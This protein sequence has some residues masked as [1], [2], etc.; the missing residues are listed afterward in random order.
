MLRRTPLK[1]KRETPRRNEGR[2]AH[3]RL[4]PRAAGKTA[5]EARH[6][7]KVASL[8]CLI[9]AGPANIHHVMH[10]PG[11]EKRRDHRFVAPLCR[12]HHQGDHGVHGKYCGSEKAFEALWGVDLVRWCIHAWLLRD[13]PDA[14]FWTDGVTRC[15]EIA[16]ALGP[17]H[18][19]G[20]GAPR[21]NKALDPPCPTARVGGE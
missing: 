16:K 18:K 10:A 1:A 14:L 19:G 17:G 3:Q 2:V 12:E 7:E 4:K 8:G 6:L 5:E 11:K 13:T 9:C 21:T 15:R 20:R